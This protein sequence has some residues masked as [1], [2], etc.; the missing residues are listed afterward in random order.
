MIL[1]WKLRPNLNKVYKA[2]F[3]GIC[4]T[5][6]LV[7]R[8]INKTLQLIINTILYQKNLIRKY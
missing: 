7:F 1:I 5:D 4:S 3:D 6:I 2:D 8:P